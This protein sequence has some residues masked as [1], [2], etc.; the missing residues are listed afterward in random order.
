MPLKGRDITRAVLLTVINVNN[1]ITKDYNKNY[2]FAYTTD[3]QASIVFITVF[4]YSVFAYL[5]RLHILDIKAVFFSLGWG[6]YT[7]ISWL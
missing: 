7:L 3:T 2:E 1:K 6:S 5:L 4:L